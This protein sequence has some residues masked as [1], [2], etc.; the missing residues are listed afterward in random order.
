MENTTETRFKVDLTKEGRRSTPEKTLLSQLKYIEDR[1]MAG[2]RSNKWNLTIERDYNFD[3]GSNTHY[4]HANF[5]LD[6]T[7][8]SNVN[9]ESEYILCH[10]II[11]KAAGFHRWDCVNPPES[12]ES[13]N[14]QPIS[15][16]EVV[17]PDN[18]YSDYFD[19]I[20]NRG[21]QI[22][23]VNSCVEAGIASGFENRFH[24]VLYGD[25]ACGKSAI[26]H[27]FKEMLGDDA[28]LVYDA[29]NTTQAGAIKDLADRIVMP[30]LLIVEEIEKC[31]EA[32]LRWLLS[33]LDFRG[34]IRKVNAR[35]QLQ[36]DVRLV[37][38]ATVNDYQLFKKMMY[39][40]L[41]SRF[42]HHVYCPRPDKDILYR[43]LEREVDAIGGDKAWIQPAIDFAEICD[44]NDPRRVTAICLCGKDALLNGTYQSNIYHSAPPEVK[45]KIDA[46]GFFNN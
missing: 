24:T 25:P 42:A 3:P 26:A 34:E 36:K 40:A 6:W 2:N 43:I 15:Y 38:V 35:T 33:V 37:C 39:G 19:H 27:G 1:L 14:S 29:T 16:A 41:A 30:R 7:G 13:D 32:S 23:I 22:E 46:S 8:S 5:I 21:P 11:H 31:D 9:P 28:V 45:A 20:Y 44:E 12:E 10:K 4:Y 18:W 17:I